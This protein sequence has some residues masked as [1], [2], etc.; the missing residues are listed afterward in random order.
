M[1]FRGNLAAKDGIS[2][3]LKLI[4]LVFQQAGSFLETIELVMEAEA[5]HPAQSPKGV[6]CQDEPLC[7]PL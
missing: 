2:Y 6:M 5:H 4:S 1:L 3:F 7:S